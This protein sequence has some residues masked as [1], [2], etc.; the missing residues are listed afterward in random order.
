MAPAVVSN[1]PVNDASPV[2]CADAMLALPVTSSA[3]VLTLFACATV[4]PL[5]FA[6]VSSAAAMATVLVPSNEGNGPNDDANKAPSAVAVTPEDCMWPSVPCTATAPLPP[7]AKDATATLVLAAT[8]ALARVA[9]SMV[10]PLSRSVI[11]VA[12]TTPSAPEVSIAGPP[13][14]AA[15][16]VPSFNTAPG[17]RARP[18]VTFNACTSRAVAGPTRPVAS[19]PRS[20]ADGRAGRTRDAACTCMSERDAPT[21]RELTSTALVIS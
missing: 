2:N 3:S 15:A 20:A 19:V 13:S 10:V 1:A 14:A 11:A 17:A 5:I 18:D 8:F 4:P 9:P 12:V 7:L 21:R 16:P 6:S